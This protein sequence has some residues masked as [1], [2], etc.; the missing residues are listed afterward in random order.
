MHPNYEDTRRLF[1]T[2]TLAALAQQFTPDQLR[3]AEGAIKEQIYT[4]YTDD[5]LFHQF[6]QMAAE[7]RAKDLAFAEQYTADLT[8]QKATKA[9]QNRLTAAHRATEVERSRAEE[10]EAKVRELNWAMDDNSH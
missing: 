5:V 6:Q 9:H 1:L 10:A 4:T 7:K 3:A 8:A 2:N